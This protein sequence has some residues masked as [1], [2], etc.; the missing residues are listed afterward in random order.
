MKIES[1]ALLFTLSLLFSCDDQNPKSGNFHIERLEAAENSQNINS[2]DDV[3][4]SDVIMYTTELMPVK[5]K[6]GILSIYE[7]IFSRD[8]VESINYVVD[9]S[10]VI[11]RLCYE[12]GVLTTK[13]RDRSPTSQPFKAIFKKQHQDYKIIEISFGKEEDLKTELPKMLP[14]SGEFHVGLKTC[15]FDEK[16]SGNGRLLSF[17]LW[18]PTRS[19]SSD[20]L[21][22]RNE[23]VISSASSFHGFPI[24]ATSYFSEI[25]SHSI[26]NAPAISESTFPVLIYNHGYGGYSQVYQ[27]IFEDLASHGYI[28]VSIGHEDESALLM[29]EDGT[30][31]SN[32]PDNEFYL[33]RA[34]EL[35]GPEIGRWQNVI[36]SSNGV[37]A[38]TEAYREMLRL[39]PLHNESTRLWQSDTETAIDHLVRMNNQDKD[40]SGVFNLDR[41]GI[42]G[43]SLG[44]ATAGQ[45]C[46]E[47]PKIKAGINLD[48]FQFGDLFN[49]ELDVPFMFVSSNPEGNRY[50]RASTFISNSREDCY[51][52]SIKGFSH[53]SFTDLKYVTEGDK[54]AMELQRSLIRSFFDKYLK[55]KSV[56]LKEIEK[57]YP[58]ISI[59]FSNLDE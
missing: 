17:Q 20:K 45:M 53:D 55:D 10:N 25:E 52:I 9:S 23:E 1:I 30:V 18:Y 26:L 24:F 42:F 36:L 47:N 7:F 16:H 44:G 14:P 48:G 19:E 12:Y 38:N 27:T 49:N 35:N 6:S 22:F 56:N 32:S 2:I 37:E 15:F 50:L 57:E 58:S 31:V 46:F 8:D 41:I 11:N 33:K 4:D 54:E 21:P 51:Q 5:G 40:L 34:P 13:R 43:H 59:D 28:V 29:K 3:I 39:T